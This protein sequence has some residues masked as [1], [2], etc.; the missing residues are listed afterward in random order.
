MRV[1]HKPHEGDRGEE[2]A[3][4]GLQ[5]AAA[6]MLAHARGPGTGSSPVID[7]LGELAES[8]GQC[9]LEEQ[10]WLGVPGAWR[11]LRAEAGAGCC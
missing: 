3:A 10:V 4:Q 1:S 5:R 6:S 11:G 8:S 2:D 7:G 9:V